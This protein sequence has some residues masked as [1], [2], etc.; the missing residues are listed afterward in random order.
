MKEKYQRKKGQNQQKNIP[1]FEAS[2]K[3]GENVEEIFKA[4][5]KKISEVYIDIQKEKGLN[6]TPKGKKRKKCC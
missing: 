3:S 2:A 6:L 4:L 1:F 5:Y